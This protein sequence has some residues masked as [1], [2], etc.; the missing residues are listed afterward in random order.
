MQHAAELQD[1]ESLISG[2]QRVALK[3]RRY[4][5]IEMT[6][7]VTYGQP[8]TVRTP[9]CLRVPV[10]V[11]G[12]CEGGGLPG[13]SSPLQVEANTAPTVA[14]PAGPVLARVV[15]AE[16]PWLTEAGSRLRAGKLVAFP[17]GDFG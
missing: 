17:T 14:A 5:C 11:F 9:R 15:P 3:R 4:S 6:A 2:L 1:L 7:I 12:S 16:E 13:P 8:L 10:H